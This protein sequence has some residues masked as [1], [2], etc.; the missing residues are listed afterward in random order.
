MISLAIYYFHF[1]SAAVRT[2]DLI[3]R[4]PKYPTIADVSNAKTLFIH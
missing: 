2:A 1:T 3:V 4:S